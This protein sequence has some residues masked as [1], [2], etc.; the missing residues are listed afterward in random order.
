M[1]LFS[2]ACA[3]SKQRC[4][5]FAEQGGVQ[6]IWASGGLFNRAIEKA[7]KRGALSAVLLTKYYLGDQM[8]SETSRGPEGKD[9]LQDLGLDGKIISKW[10]FNKWDGK[11]WIGLIWLRIGTGWGACE[12]GNEHSGSIKCGEFLD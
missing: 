9:Y 10:I 5:N 8:R 1:I 12:C 3:L 11:A 7:T 4:Y 2:V 6:D